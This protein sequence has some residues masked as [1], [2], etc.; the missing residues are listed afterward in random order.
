M[1][2]SPKIEEQNRWASTRSDTKLA[3]TGAKDTSTATAV[4]ANNA[5]QN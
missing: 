3:P 4:V 5:L 1:I 2:N